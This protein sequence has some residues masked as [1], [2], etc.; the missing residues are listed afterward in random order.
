MI[1]V[2]LYWAGAVAVAPCDIAPLMKRPSFGPF[3]L[4]E[5]C[6]WN[7]D[8]TVSRTFLFYFWDFFFCP[9]SSGSLV[10]L[11]VCPFVCFKKMRDVFKFESPECASHSSFC[12]FSSVAYRVFAYLCNDA[13]APCS[14]RLY[15]NITFRKFALCFPGNF[16]S[17]YFAQHTELHNPV[18]RLIFQIEFFLPFSAGA[19]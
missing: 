14:F 3:V 11:L 9:P 19:F 18:T 13:F 8:E 5:T 16:A 6:K 7:C 12:D 17:S 2:H 15:V 1:S 4:D 10:R